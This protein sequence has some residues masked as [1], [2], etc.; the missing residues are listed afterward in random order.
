MYINGKKLNLKRYS[1]GELKLSKSELNKHIKNN[2]IEILY[3][4]NE[5]FFELLLILDY[6][7]NLKLN[8]DYKKLSFNENSN[9]EDRIYKD[10]YNNINNNTLLNIDLI[11]S[12]L[13]YQRMD[14]KGTD[15]VDTL[16]NVGNIINNLNLNS[17]TICEPHSKIDDIKNSKEF[18]YIKHLKQKVFDE[19]GYDEQNIQIVFTDKGA[20]NRYGKLFKSA[21]YFNK[22]RN[23]NTG[24]I[25]KHEIVGN[26]DPNKNFIIVDDIISTGDTIVNIVNYLSSLN[27]KNIYIFCGHFEKNKY[28]K[29]LFKMD[30]IK[31]I[32]STN[33]LSKRQNTKLKLYD[34]KE[35]FYGK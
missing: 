9:V 30:N 34:V 33:S 32:F 29:R 21:V 26:V 14:H 15:E 11:L 28:N 27:V 1:S 19:I 5:R 22:E 24:L 20:L 6:Y 3:D 17:V 10:I 18:S 8:P 2:Q 23:K 16:T 13:P 25:I 4:G 31:K 12:Y 7:K 35:I